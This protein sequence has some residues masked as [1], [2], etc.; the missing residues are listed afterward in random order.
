[1]FTQTPR[2]VIDV[3]PE[4]GFRGFGKPEEAF[5]LDS[6]SNSN[7][8]HTVDLK[9]RDLPLE[10]NE[11]TPSSSFFSRKNSHKVTPKRSKLLKEEHKLTGA[12]NPKNELNLEPKKGIVNRLFKST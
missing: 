2:A 8:R 4:D 7:K 5:D 1:M 11:T 10:P 12:D 3:D 9:M 6:A